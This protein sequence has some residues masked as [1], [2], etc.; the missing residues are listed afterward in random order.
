VLAQFQ[1]FLIEWSVNIQHP[2]QRHASILD[3]E[4]AFFP[5]NFSG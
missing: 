3:K 1:A 5:D 4:I 2:R